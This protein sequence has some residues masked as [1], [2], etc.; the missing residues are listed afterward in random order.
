LV[1]GRIFQGGFP[2]SWLRFDQFGELR[3]FG[4]KAEV[5]RRQHPIVRRVRVHL[6]SLSVEGIQKNQVDP[7]S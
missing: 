6:G 1:L 2:T 5:D 7:P 3:P 4:L